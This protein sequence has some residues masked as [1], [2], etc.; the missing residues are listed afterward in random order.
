MLIDNSEYTGEITDMI[1][2]AK[3]QKG[4]SRGRESLPV[5]D[6]TMA[7][8]V[9]DLTRVAA[10]QVSVIEREQELQQLF[11]C[12]LRSRYNNGIVI[13]PSGSGKTSLVMELARRLV[14]G[15]APSTLSGRLLVQVNALALLAGSSV[16]GQLEQRLA[17]LVTE[18]QSYQGKLIP[19]F[20][21]LEW[22]A[23]TTSGSL[24]R[25]LEPLLESTIPVVATASRLDAEWILAKRFSQVVLGSVD[26]RQALTM[27]DAHVGNLEHH[28]GVRVLDGARTHAV[29]VARRYLA[30]AAMPGSV[31]DLLD[32]AC[33]AAQV[34]GA[35][36]VT[37]DLVS[38]VASRLTGLPLQRLLDSEVLRLS[39]LEEILRRRVVGQDQA[40][41]TVAASIRRARAGL[42][43]PSRPLGVFLFVGPTGV[44]KTELARTVAELLF[45]DETAM[46]RIDMS[47]F[48]ERHQIARLIGAPPGYVGYGEGGQLTEA[49]RARPY[50]L[51]LLDELEKAHP[52]VFNLLLQIM[53]DGRLTDGRGQT[54]DFR[55]TIVVMTS[56]AGSEH[57]AHLADVD[58]AIVHRRVMEAV[59]GQFKP[60]FL[61]RLDDV[62][63]FNRLDI[64][65][66][67][68][69]V[70]I[71]V[72]QLRQRLEAHGLVLV[73]S[74]EARQWLADNGYDIEYGARPLRRLVQRTLG[75]D[76]ARR[77]LSGEL[78][79]GG[80][81]TVDVGSDGLVVHATVEPHVRAGE[82]IAVG[83]QS[84]TADG[85]PDSA[86]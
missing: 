8:Y 3:D 67:H 18:L 73:L 56:N 49:V 57:I 20:E 83:V 11:E 70:D 55:N 54:V 77:V 16:R 63:V 50:T 71:Q 69:I 86:G 78:N 47:E 74:D 37:V 66:L 43:D 76:L 68:S 29:Q 59:K 75:D 32:Q 9:S 81:L 7:A 23:S 46:V 30:S 85:S 84:A 48:M 14:S 61:N 34:L 26:D 51:V 38:V 15:S 53:E 40:V 6:A 5:I 58:G 28:H 25:H 24:L 2:K 13:G 44:G 65:T 22:F 79:L 41:R 72:D 80:T 35:S 42:A 10:K 4:R 45:D 52:D 82:E 12:L 21:E 60:E 19:V 31:I 36:D 33:A 62:I 27:L 1:G 39:N 17:A 64:E